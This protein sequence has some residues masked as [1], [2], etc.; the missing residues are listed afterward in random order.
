[1]IISLSNNIATLALSIQQE[2]FHNLHFID[3]RQREEVAYP[4]SH[5]TTQLGEANWRAISV[6]QPY[7]KDKF[8][9]RWILNTLRSCVA[10][11]RGEATFLL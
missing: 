3:D 6:Q 2:D 11:G 9:M 5:I 1:M 4:R 7:N 10:A 8:I